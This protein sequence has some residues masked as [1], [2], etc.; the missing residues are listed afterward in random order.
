MRHPTRPL[1]DIE[2]IRPSIRELVIKTLENEVVPV[3]NHF[4]AACTQNN[5]R[6]IKEVDKKLKPTLDLTT[7]IC[8]RARE[9][10]AL[11]EPA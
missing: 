4:R 11:S 10:A 2:H 5:E 8:C 1:F 6:F 3:I 9:E 7:D